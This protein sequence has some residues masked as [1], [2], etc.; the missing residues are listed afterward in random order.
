M[1]HQLRIKDMQQTPK[2][3]V[4][5]KKRVLEKPMQR[6]REPVPRLHSADSR[7]GF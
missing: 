3:R 5:L 4:N 2:E 1:T 7:T 6:I